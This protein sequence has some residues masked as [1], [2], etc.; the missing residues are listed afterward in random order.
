M[1]GQ[2]AFQS[3]GCASLEAPLK[4]SGQVFGLGKNLRFGN[5]CDFFMRNLTQLCK[6][7]GNFAN[8]V[9]ANRV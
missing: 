6:W 2:S 1:C 8:E 3:F 4:I 7:V 9:S 5:F